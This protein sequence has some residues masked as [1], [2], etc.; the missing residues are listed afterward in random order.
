MISIKTVFLFFILLHP[1][2]CYSQ[3]SGQASIKA[4]WLN[5]KTA[6]HQLIA[7]I[8]SAEDLG[9]DINDYDSKFAEE[10][11]KNALPLLSPVDSLTADKKLTSIALKFFT[12][13]LY[14]KDAP[15]LSYNGIDYVPACLALEDL[16]IASVADNTFSTLLDRLESK[17]PEY[18][19]VKTG[20]KTTNNAQKRSQLIRT[21]NTIR[22]MDCLV[23]TQPSLI[24]VNIPSASL[25]MYDNGKIAFESKVIVGKISTR[26]PRFITELSNVT[27][28]PFWNVPTSIAIKELLPDIKKDITYLE[29]N[30]FQVLN[31][32][33]KV[34]NPKSIDWQSLNVSYFPYNIRQSTGCDNSLGLIKFNLNTPFNVYLHDTPWKVLFESN[35]RFYS[36]G[37]IRVHRAKELA[38]RIL[39]ANSIAVDTLDENASPL[40]Y[41]QTVVKIGSGIPVLVL[42]NTVW[43]DLAGRLEYYPDIYGLLKKSG[44]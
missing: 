4:N 18:A 41:K 32:S 6:I 17:R 13:V 37:C 30:N 10:V 14:G 38:H 24:V 27:I 25:V 28:Y 11:T 43:F 1:L 39:G 20:L 33:G 21:L 34:L 44:E 35:K 36:H 15:D 29:R 3:F 22:W 7:Y 42:Y 12:H 31:K 5:N 16:I 9:L 23:I 26:T 8:C 19:L 2:F 40:R